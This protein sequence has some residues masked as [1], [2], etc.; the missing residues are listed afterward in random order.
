VSVPADTVDLQG[1]TDFTVAL[2]GTGE[3]WTWGGNDNGE[4]GL[5]HR[6]TSL[7]SHQVQLPRVT[8]ISV[9]ESHVLAL[10][11]KGEL[12]AWG[13]NHHGQLGDGTGDDRTTPHR[14]LE[15]EPQARLAT[16]I[17]SS[18]VVHPD[19][20]VITWG[21][22]MPGTASIDAAD[23]GRPRTLHLPKSVR[24]AQVDAGRRHLL[25]L[26]R[27]GELLAYGVDFA[28]R[29]MPN[30]VLLQESWGR[31]SS[32]SAGD[33]HTLA[34]TDTGVVIA[35]GANNSGQLGA[36]DTTSR[37]EPRKVTLPVDRARVLQVVASGDFS[38]ARLDDHRVLSW[39]HGVFGQHGNG[40]SVNQSRP[41]VVP[42]PSG[43]RVA[44]IHAGRFHAHVRTSVHH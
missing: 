39:G 26:T 7:R 43:T 36:R 8:A 37:P 23:Y 25:V 29:P 19:G 28:G 21:K 6:R 34:L 2:T 33:S 30:K 3:V 14:I 31:V 1:G 9:G 12:Y 20:T 10:T 35:W 16:G 38:L 11:A 17:A 13:R 41:A 42:L 40:N 24:A 32:I 4:L 44:G 22:P 18:A 5:G 27:D 15:L